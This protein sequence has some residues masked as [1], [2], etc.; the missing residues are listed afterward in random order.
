[1]SL[2]LKKIAALTT[3]AVIPL[4]LAACGSNDVN[5]ALASSD[6]DCSS[7]DSSTKT[8][9]N[10]VG[11]PILSNGA[12]YLGLDQGIFEKHGL[13]ATITMVPSLPAATSAVLGGTAD[14]GFTSTM[15]LLQAAEQGQ[16]LRGVAPFAGIE[17][18]YFDK[19]EAGE[20]GYETGVNALLVKEDS[21][22]DSL[23]DLEGKTVAVA[24][25]ALSDLLTKAAISRD[26]GN[27]DEVRFVVMTGPDAYNAV[28]AGKVDAAQSFVPIINGYEE[29]GL[30]NLSWLEV[31]V[32][33]DGPT[34][35]MVSSSD[36]VEENPDTVARFECAIV[37]AGEY[38]NEHQDEVRAVT[39][40]E[41]K[42]DPATLAGAVVP[43]FYTEID[44]D[45]VRRIE[46]L[47]VEFGF[48]KSKLDTDEVLVDTSAA[49]GE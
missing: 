10:I 24:D 47:M 25:P 29:K 46:D 26:G 33:H 30:K 23:A 27:L 15:S 9:I 6:Y 18:G 48:L 22:I 12:L 44:V 31:E 16:Q 13:D 2:V 35:L 39:A 14:F 36:Y 21:G 8:D 34:S 42:V 28:L 32:L 4:G 11:M 3:V 37:E 5:A 7:P 43:Y 41:Q 45:G 1:M 20:E 17:P 19:M 38:S 40:R 49:G